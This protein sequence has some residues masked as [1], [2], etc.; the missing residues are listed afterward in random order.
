MKNPISRRFLASLAFFS[1]ALASARAEDTL[2][3][4]T[5]KDLKPGEALKEAPY[6]APSSSPQKVTTDAQNTLAGAKAVGSLQTP[7]LFDKETDSHYTPALTLKATAPITTGVITIK[8]D[9]LFD[10]VSPSAAHPVATL[11]AFPFIDGEGGSTYIPIIACSGPADL[12]L[13]GAGFAKAKQINFKVGDVAHLK[14]VLDLTKHTFQMFLNDAALSEPEHDD[15]KFGS[16]LGF[17]IRDGTAL[18]GNNGETFTAG[19]ANLV[20]TH[21]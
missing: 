2:W 15:G 10:R 8:W 4:L 16:F 21:S 18:G 3:N 19:I 9:V 6:I 11:M 7:L 13:G 1:L 5:F 14:A 12:F 20:V 17:T